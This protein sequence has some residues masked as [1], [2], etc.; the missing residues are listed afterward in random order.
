MKTL[1]EQTNRMTQAIP[2]AY[3]SWKSPITADLIVANTISLIGTAIEGEDTY[4]LE[5]RPAEEGRSVL[6]RQT[7]DGISTEVNAQPYSVRNGVH[8]YGGGSFVVD[9][10]RVVFS[11]S[12][13]QRLYCQRLDAA[14]LGQ[15]PRPLTPAPIANG[16]ALRYADGT[17]DRKGDARGDRWIGIREAH[18]GE[19]E[20]T[21]TIVAVAL[22]GPENGPENDPE[23]DPEDPGQI[24]VQGSDFYAAPRIS[25]DG[26]QLAWICWSH[27]H[28]PWDSTELWVA[29]FQA[30]G[31]LGEATLVAG[32]PQESIVQPTW[33]PDG[34][35][36]FVSDRTDWWNIYRWDG[37]TIE[38]VC[39]MQAEFGQPQWV[40]CMDSFAFADAQRLVCTYS[41]NGLWYLGILDTETGELETLKSP[42]TEISDVQARGD[43]AIF[44]AGSATSP[45]AVVQLNLQSR[46]LTVLRSSSTL[47]ID[48]DYLSEPELITFPTRSGA[49]ETEVAHGIYYAPK[50]PDHS[51]TPGERPP[52]LVKSHGGPTAAARSC[53]NL[54][55]QFWTSRGFAVLDVNYRGSTGYGRPYRERLKGQWGVVDVDDCVAGA[56][57]LTERGAVDGDRLT[58]DGGS[59]GGYTTLCALIFH[60]VFKAGA[61]RYGVSDLTALAEDTHKFESRYLDSLIG[62]YPASKAL[63]EQRSPIHHA[64]HLSCPVIFFQ[65][66]EDRVVP[67]NQTESM[68]AALRSKGLPVAYVPFEG[69]QHGFRKA[70]NIKRTLEGELF[71]YAQVFGFELADGIE[72]LEIANLT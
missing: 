40:F 31:S 52:L 3:G 35:L 62:P 68:V 24:L 70:E 20:P 22:N 11:N 15:A 53:L 25:P 67:P 49:G 54:G 61:S 60:N 16:L 2:A 72:P 7:P 18:L 37:Q 63:Y 26:R 42:Y 8:E 71:F 12:A 46:K 14:A 39:P 30:D 29:S 69:E 56:Q 17:I 45:T 44:I 28:M 1:T 10:G 64:D 33:S 66:L 23:N 21:N 58:I 19:A 51:G 27:P 47:E 4:W 32:G 13:D 5:M 41:R 55:I 6:V 34:R 38:A 59:A 48:P 50:N 36:Y 57:Y 65:G 43:R 9:G